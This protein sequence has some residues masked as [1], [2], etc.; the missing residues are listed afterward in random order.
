MSTNGNISGQRLRQLRKLN[1]LDLDD[2]AN[3]VGISGSMLSRFE[4][5]KV[6]SIRDPFKVERL[7]KYLKKLEIKS[8]GILGNINN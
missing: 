3:A 6:K 8:R 4:R 7:A 1:D 2:V 5:G